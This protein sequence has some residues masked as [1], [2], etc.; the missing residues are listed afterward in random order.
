[1]AAIV[2]TISAATAAGVWAELRFGGRA[3]IASRRALIFVLYA[4]LPPATF[5]N[6]ARVEFDAD[7]GIGI[8]LAY[9]A[10]AGA[11]PPARFLPPP[12]TGRWPPRWR[13][14]AP[15]RRRSSSCSPCL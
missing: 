9:V 1:M 3:G 10:L 13:S 14:G 15:P 6:L 8:A 5:F 7:V 12:P 4:V 2:A 11:A